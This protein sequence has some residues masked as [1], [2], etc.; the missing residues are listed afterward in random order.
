MYKNAMQRL[1]PCVRRPILLL[2]QS[3]CGRISMRAFGL[4]TLSLL[5]LS[6]SL[7]GCGILEWKDKALDALVARI[8]PDMEEGLGEQILPTFLPAEAIIKDEV[9]QTRIERLL[10]PLI[11]RNGIGEPR[12]KIY[13]S[14]EA[15]LN[16]FALPG[17]ILIFNA[18]MLMAAGSPEEILGVAAHELAHVTEKHVLKSM[19]QSLSLAAIV[20]FFLGDV[21]ALG[22]YILQQSQMLLQNGFTRTQEA[23]ADQIGFDY[24]VNAGVHPK[25]MSQFFQRL[26]QKRKEGAET[27]AENRSLQRMSVFLSTHPLTTERIRMVEDRLAALTD[28]Q[29]KKL[30]PVSFELKE[31]QDRLSQ[32]MN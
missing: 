26:E 5:L 6:L 19:I 8:P 29:K 4:K 13:L 9:L 30:K 20:S 15:E 17:G 21:S 23:E 27:A 14:R 12:I 25:G 16:A 31:F 32:R 3:F 7:S 22:A 10:K 11:E 24:L 18:G 2:C 1:E 28:A